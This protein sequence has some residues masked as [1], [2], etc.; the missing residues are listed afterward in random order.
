MTSAQ[1]RAARGLLNWTVRDLSERS[2]LHRNT[3]TNF[4]TGRYAGRPEAVDAMQS[5]LES[6]GVVFLPQNGNG[7]G[8]ALRK[9]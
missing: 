6:G 8:V 3:V 1:A 5:A 2:G 9:V 4:E 7:P